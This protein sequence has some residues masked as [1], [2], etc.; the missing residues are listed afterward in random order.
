PGTRGAFL[1]TGGPG[2]VQPVVTLAVVAPTTLPIVNGSYSPNPFTITATVANT[3]AA[4]A[5]DVA[6]TV[7]L[8]DGLTL[9]AGSFTQSIGNLPIGQQHDVSW[10]IRAA[11]QKQDVMLTYFITAM[12][13]NAAGKSVTRQT[14]V[15]GGAF[16][17]T[18]DSVTPSVG[19]DTGSATVHI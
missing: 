4:T 14:T 16:A 17:L 10:S 5:E 9:A 7:F 8:P 12:P 11:G 3:G 13:S 6:L 15:P 2:T 1:F 19:G 18:A